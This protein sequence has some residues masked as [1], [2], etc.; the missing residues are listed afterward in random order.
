MSSLILTI[1]NFG[2]PNFDPYPYVLKT[3]KDLIMV[4][5]KV[6]MYSSQKKIDKDLPSNHVC[7]PQ[8]S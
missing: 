6:I 5:V 4:K 8:F 7:F 1:H 3:P 2:V